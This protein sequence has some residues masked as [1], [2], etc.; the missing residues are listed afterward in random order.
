MRRALLIGELSFGHDQP[1][2]ATHANNLA[3]LLQATNRLAEA[4]PLMRRVLHIDEISFGHDHP[5]VATDRNT[6]AALLQ[7]TNRLAEAEPL[8]RRVMLMLVEFTPR[9]GREHPHLDVGLSNYRGLLEALGNSPDQ[10]RQRLRELDNSLDPDDS[11][12]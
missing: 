6:L 2:V 1:R 5:R 9:I 11:L 12:A 4:E 7:A 3:T 8:M 10:I